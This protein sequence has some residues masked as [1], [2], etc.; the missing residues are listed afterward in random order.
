MGE[1]A[2]I[3]GELT[4][5]AWRAAKEQDLPV[6]AATDDPERLERI[7]RAQG[8]HV[9]I[10]EI[11]ALD[12]AP[13]C[14]GSALPVLKTPLVTTSRAGHPDAANSPAVLASIDRAL[15]ATLGGAASAMV[16]NP[17]HKATLYAAGFG[18]PGHTEYLAEAIAARLHKPPAH[19]VM[20][21]TARDLRVVPVT[22]HNALKDAI[23]A[24]TTDRIVQT[25]QGAAAALRQDLAIA[26]P[27]LAI[28][29]LNP[30]AGEA[31]T[32]GREEIEII[33][34]AV[35]TLRARGLTVD[36]PLP[37]D[38]LFHEDARRSY[39][40]V[41]CMYHDQALI[42][43]KTVDFWGGVNVTLGLDIVRTSPDHGTALAL[44][45]S[46]KANPTSFFAALRCA[47]QIADNRARHGGG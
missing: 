39:D 23:A 27:R 46:G 12:E 21:L 42:P 6:F 13:G 41:V 43:L 25:A 30:H 14:F 11:A 16:T 38:T 18:A 28:A 7:A 4:L 45:G 19:P 2:G 47:S 36:G 8:W 9:P 32:L 1:P 15:D 33:M 26:V 29:A 5:T 44:A 37:A 34:P 31:G 40:A 24:L 10:K 35:E 20:M 22:I 17:I 3:G